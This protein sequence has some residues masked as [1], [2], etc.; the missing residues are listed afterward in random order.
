MLALVE[1]S[2]MEQR[3][4]AVIEIQNGCP[5]T[6][7]AARYGVSRQTI[8]TWKNRYLQGGLAALSDHS[9]RPRVCPRRTSAEIEAAV[10]EMRRLHPAGAAAAWPTNWAAW[11]WARPV[12]PEIQRPA[13]R[14]LC[15]LVEVRY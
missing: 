1:L 13:L 4:R 3:Y 12:V 9:H 14:V 15:L 5:L 7:V 2:I 11:A 6:E 10:C 8:H